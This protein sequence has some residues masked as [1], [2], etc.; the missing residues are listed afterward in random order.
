M[1]RNESTNR[2]VAT[3]AWRAAVG[4]V[5]MFASLGITGIDV[6]AAEQATPATV[7]AVRSVAITVAD[8]DRAL[9]FYQNALT[10]QAVSDKEVAG[11]AYEHL[12]GVFGLRLRIVALQLGDEQIELLQFLA[13]AGRPI[14]PESKSN[15]LWFQHVAIVVSD[16]DVAYARLRTFHVQHASSGPQTLPVWNPNAGGIKAFYFR[17]PDGN[18][19]EILEFP[20][21]KGAAKWHVHDERLFLG[22]DHTAIAVA[23]TEA[24]L[25]FYCDGLGLKIA[26]KSENYGTEQEHLNNVFGARLRITALRSST[27]PGVELLEYLSPRTGRAMPVDTKANDLWHWHVLMDGTVDPMVLRRLASLGG[28]LV[29]PGVVVLPARDTGF[30]SGALVR[31]ADGHAVLIA[32]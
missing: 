16:M 7:H 25:R 3:V 22:I 32:Q 31:D 26:G 18:H 9:R 10:F 1:W 15:D 2:W 30:A 8:M 29:S 6:V 24:S 12:F 5:F 14:P 28:R 23:D 20:K 19:L 13:P 21:D 11:E 4:L 17:D 27:G